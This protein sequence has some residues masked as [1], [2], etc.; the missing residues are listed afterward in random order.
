[1]TTERY[2]VPGILR[3]ATEAELENERR[4]EVRQRLLGPIGMR[5]NPP[6]PRRKLGELARDCVIEKARE[7]VRDVEDFICDHCD[8]RDENMV[9][10]SRD[11]WQE[12]HDIVDDLDTIE[13]EGWEYD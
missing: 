3:D 8:H 2:D 13:K 5:P 6:P 11:F 9:M 4:D 7:I 1:M 10:L 12:L